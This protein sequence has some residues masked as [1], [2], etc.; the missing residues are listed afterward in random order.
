[1][2]AVPP[3]ASLP[4]L[5]GPPRQGLPSAPLPENISAPVGSPP[6]AV[7]LPANGTGNQTTPQSGGTTNGG[8]AN[9]TTT[10]IFRVSARPASA[11]DSTDDRTASGP[12]RTVR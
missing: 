5:Q 9:S 7:K 12:E 11:A 8:Q 1:V 10:W 3:P 6:P 2:V 4:V